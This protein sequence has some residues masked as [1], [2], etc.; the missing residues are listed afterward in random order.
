MKQGGPGVALDQYVQFYQLEAGDQVELKE[1][2]RALEYVSS[3]TQLLDIADQN[4]WIPDEVLAERRSELSALRQ[5][6]AQIGQ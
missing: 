4:A 3:C 6:I 5:Q 2:Q 1:G